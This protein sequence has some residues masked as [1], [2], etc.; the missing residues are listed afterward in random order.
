M[1]KNYFSDARTL[2]DVKQLYKKLAR[3]LH[4]DC[5]PGKDTTAAFQDM[6][7]QYN[8]AF[9]RLKN[10]HVNKDG[11]TY[12]KE[13]EE[14]PEQY[15]DIINAL[16]RCPGL[17]IELCGSWL[18]VTGNTK[19]HK[20]ILKELHFRWSKNKAAW[21]FHFE[22]FRKRSKGSVDLDTIRAMYGS[23]RFT[24]R[25]ASQYEELPA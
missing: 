10:I 20:D 13:T 19:D 3:E 11:E 23:Q 22:P 25:T 15:A 24:E 1:N 5:N 21:Y 4:P 2:E 7:R 16:L 12:E 8:E 14:T 9:K 18:W 6:Q 17:V